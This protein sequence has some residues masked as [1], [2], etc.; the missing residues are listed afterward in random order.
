MVTHTYRR[1]ITTEFPRPKASIVHALGM[2]DVMASGDEEQI[3]A[4]GDVEDLPRPWEPASCPAELRKDI[5]EWVD[6][7]VAWLN[8]EY[9]W[10]TPSVIPECWPMHPHIAR[11]LP[12]L[13][14]LRWHAEEALE[15]APMEE[16]NRYAYPM[17]CDRLDTRLGGAGSGCRNGEHTDWPAEGRYERYTSPESAEVRDAAIMADTNPIARIHSG[18]TT[19]S[20]A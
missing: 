12:V 4:L 1:L 16:W 15:P 14:V 19:T 20:R 6:L 17:F 9:A 3:A 13:A 2:L 11:E 10:R 5:W 8:R 7:V 18:R